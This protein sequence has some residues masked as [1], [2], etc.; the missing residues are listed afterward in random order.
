MSF[1]GGA[2]RS[3][4]S[5]TVQHKNNCAHKTLCLGNDIRKTLQFCTWSGRSRRGFFTKAACYLIRDDI[6]VR[7]I[8][9]MSC[10]IFCFYI[11]CFALNFSILPVVSTTFCLPEKNGWHLSQMSIFITLSL[12]VDLVVNVFPQAQTT[13]VSWQFG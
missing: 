13:S 7:E 1:R 10:D 11:L 12:Y 2:W 8:K 3:E 5:R 6:F 9:K 4:K